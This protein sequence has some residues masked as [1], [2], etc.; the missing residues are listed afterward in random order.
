MTNVTK[1]PDTAWHEAILA[2]A[3]ATRREAMG[4]GRNS[5][6]MIYPV[7]PY[8]VQEPEFKKVTQEVMKLFD[9]DEAQA[10][11]AIVGLWC[12]ANAILSKKP[13]PDHWNV[14]AKGMKALMHFR[15]NAEQTSKAK[16]LPTEAGI[17]DDDFDNEIPF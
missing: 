6:L 3:Q 5:K 17:K 14:G 12:C 11:T 10:E 4:N 16:A 8:I 15:M 9:L 7:T 2:M 1:F 13:R